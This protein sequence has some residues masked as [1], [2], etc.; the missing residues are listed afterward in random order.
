MR[1]PTLTSKGRDSAE[2]LGSP[3]VLD[4]AALTPL[5]PSACTVCSPYL[6]VPRYHLK[7]L[8]SHFTPV[9]EQPQDLSLC[10]NETPDAICNSAPK[11]TALSALAHPPG[12]PRVQKG[13]LKDTPQTHKQQ[14]RQ[15]GRRTARL[16]LHISYHEKMMFIIKSV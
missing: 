14:H 9:P 2:I 6:S 12:R 15:E 5:C 7:S 10:G 13:V 3:T 8:F 4:T 16:P 11:A 1:R